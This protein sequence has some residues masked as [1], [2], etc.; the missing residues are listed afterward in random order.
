MNYSSWCLLTAGLRKVSES[1]V[2]RTTHNLTRSYQSVNHTI[3]SKNC[4]PSKKV[5][6]LKGHPPYK[7]KA[8]VK[9][10]KLRLENLFLPSRK[11]ANQA[12]VQKTRSEMSLRN[13]SDRRFV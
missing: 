4:N 13:Q 3:S 9:N 5:S 2:K 7:T 1:P 11:E 10:S 6:P 8:T 12:I